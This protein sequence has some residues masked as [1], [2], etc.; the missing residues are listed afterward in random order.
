[1]DHREHISCLC[2][3]RGQVPSNMGAVLHTGSTQ[4][5]SGG[6]HT[7][8]HTET[9]ATHKDTSV[10]RDILTQTPDVSTYRHGHTSSC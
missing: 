9:G 2:H 7:Q 6:L 8:I 3:R 10:H 5:V 4:D 1:M